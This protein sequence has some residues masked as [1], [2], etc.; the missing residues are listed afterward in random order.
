M[1]QSLLPF[2]FLSYDCVCVFFFLFFPKDLMEVPLIRCFAS[3]ALRRLVVRHRCRQNSAA[4]YFLYSL[5][6]TKNCIGKIDSTFVLVHRHTPVK[7]I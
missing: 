3:I 2:A 1:L 6:S 4:L 5:W 7:L